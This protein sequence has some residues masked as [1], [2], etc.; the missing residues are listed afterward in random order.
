MSSDAPLILLSTASTT[1]GPSVCHPTRIHMP[2]QEEG[3]LPAVR[4]QLREGDNI[5]KNLSAAS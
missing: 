4:R 1:R 2:G 5:W 3:T